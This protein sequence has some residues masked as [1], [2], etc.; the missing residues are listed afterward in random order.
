MDVCK[1]I[2]HALARSLHPDHLELRENEGVIGYVVSS[3]FRR[4]ESLDRQM[5]IDQVLRDSRNRLRAE[6]IKQV[7]AIVALTP[8][9]FAG[10][11]L[12]TSIPA[13]RK[14]S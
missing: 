4:M 14:T 3:R 8:E 6:E 5:L 13:K 1:K 12:A 10:H 9:E 7:I 2:E 11:E